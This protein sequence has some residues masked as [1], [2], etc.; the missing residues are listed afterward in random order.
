MILPPEIHRPEARGHAMA[1]G[2]HSSVQLLAMVEQGCEEVRCNFCPLKG[3][4]LSALGRRLADGVS[5]TASRTRCL[6]LC[7]CQLGALGLY[8][9]SSQ[10]GTDGVGLAHLSL[11]AN[12]LGSKGA[13]LAAELVLKMK[14]QRLDLES[15]ELQ[16]EGCRILSQKAL[17][18]SKCTLQHLDLRM[19][20]IQP[21]GA[22]ALAK[23]LMN[24][25]T[26]THLDLGYNRIGTAGA[27]ALC[28]V[29]KTSNVQVLRLEDNDVKDQGAKAL[30]ALQLQVLELGFNQVTA[31]GAVLLAAQLCRRG[32]RGPRRLGLGG[33]DLRDAGA[34]AFAAALQ[35]N[36]CLEELSLPNSCIGGAG[37]AA[38]ASALHS[39]W[40]LRELD[41]RDNEISLEA[42]RII[43]ETT[44]CARL[45]GDARPSSPER[46][47][48][49]LVDLSTGTRR[50][51]CSA[52][53]VRAYLSWLTK[54]LAQGDENR[55][56]L[57]AAALA[58]AIVD[59]DG[60]WYELPRLR[61]LSSLYGR[62]LRGG[63]RARAQGLYVLNL[64]PFHVTVTAAGS[65]HSA[66][67]LEENTGGALGDVATNVAFESLQFSQKTARGLQS[68]ESL[69]V[70]NCVGEVRHPLN[71]GELRV[72]N[73]RHTF[74]TDAPAHFMLLLW[75]WPLRLRAA[76]FHDLNFY[77][78]SAQAGYVGPGTADA[79]E[80]VIQPDTALPQTSLAELHMPGPAHTFVSHSWQLNVNDIFGSLQRSFAGAEMLRLWMA[81]FSLNHWTW[82][83]SQAE[84]PIEQ[85]C[86]AEVLRSRCQSFALVLG[87]ELESLKRLWCLYEVLLATECSNAQRP[88]SLKLCSP[89]GLL[90]VG[91]GGMPVSYILKVSGS[92]SNLDLRSARGENPWEQRKLLEE[93]GRRGEGCNTPLRNFLME[94]L[95]SIH[96]RGQEIFLQ[97][98]RVDAGKTSSK[99]D[100]FDSDRSATAYEDSDA[101]E[102]RPRSEKKAEQLPESEANGEGEE[103]QGEI[104]F[105]T[106]DLGTKPMVS[107]ASR[108]PREEAEEAQRQSEACEPPVAIKLESSVS[109]PSRLLV[110]APSAA[111]SAVEAAVSVMERKES[112]IERRESLLCEQV[113]KMDR[114]GTIESSRDSER[115][116]DPSAGVAA[117]VEDVSLTQAERQES[118][119]R[120]ES[121]TESET[122]QKMETMETV[123]QD[124]ER[125]GDPSAGVAAAVED[126]SLTQA[127]R[128]ESGG[129]TESLTESETSQ[130][131]ETMDRSGTIESSRDSERTGDPSASVAAAVEDVSLTQAE[132][133]RREMQRQESGGRT[134]S[135]TESETS[136]KIETMETVLQDS[137]RTGDP[138][139]GVAAAA[140]EDV[141]SLT[142]VERQES[143][144][145]TASLTESE[146]IQLMDR[147]STLESSRDG[148]RTGDPSA[149]V[150][151]ARVEDAISFTE[152]EREESCAA[153]SGSLPGSDQIQKMDPTSTVE[154]S[155]DGDKTG[156]RSVDVGAAAVK[157]VVPVAEVDR[158]GEKTGD[159]SMDV[160]AAVVVNVVFVTQVGRD[161]E[162]TVDPSVDVGAAL[163]K[164]VVPVAEV[165]RDGEKTVDPSVDVGAAAVKN[166]VPV[167][168]VDRDDDKTGDRSVDVGAAVVENVVCVTEV[169]DD[170]LVVEDSVSV[171]ECESPAGP[172]PELRRAHWWRD[173]TNGRSE[174]DSIE[175][176]IVPLSSV[177][178][179]PEIPPQTSWSQDSRFS[180]G[181]PAAPERVNSVTWGDAMN[182]ATE[183]MEF[184]DEEADILR[185]LRSRLRD[186]VVLANRLA[187]AIMS[188][189]SLELPELSRGVS[190]GGISRASSLQSRDFARLISV[191]SSGNP[192]ASCR[193]AS[194]ITFF[195]TRTHH[196]PELEGR[197]VGILRQA[198]GE[199]ADLCEQSGTFRPAAASGAAPAAPDPTKVPEAGEATGEAPKEDGGEAPREK[200][201]KKKDKSKKASKDSK[202]DQARRREAS[203]VE[204]TPGAKRGREEEAEKEDTVRLR[205]AKATPLEREPIGAR[206][207]AVIQEKVDE[208]VAKHPETFGLG[209][210]SIRGSA[211]KHFRESHGKGDERPSEPEGPPPE[212]GSGE[213]REQEG[214]RERRERSRAPLKKPAVEEEVATGQEAQQRW[215]KGFSVRL[216][217]LDP[218]ELEMCKGLVVLEGAYYHRSVTLAG[219][220]R[221]VTLTGG[222]ITLKMRL[223]GTGDEEL[224]KYHTAQA[225]P[226]VRAHVCGKECNQEEVADDLVHIVVG[227]KMREDG[228]D[229]PWVTNLEKAGPRD[230]EGD[231]LAAIRARAALEGREGALV[232]G[233]G[234]EEKPARERGASPGTQKKEKKEKKKEKKQKRAAKKRSQSGG[235]EKT[236]EA[237]KL[238]GSRAK[239]ACLKKPRTFFEGTGLDPRDRVRNRVAR[240]A[241]RHL[242]RKAEKSSSSSSQTGSG[243]SSSEALAGEEE[244]IFEQ[245]CKVRIIA[246]H[247]PGALS[248]QALRL[249]RTTLLQEI[250]SED[251][252]N[253]LQPVAMAYYRQ[254]LYSGGRVARR[255]GS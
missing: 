142:E 90:S 35:K 131:M 121:L 174:R 82:P 115:T 219:V 56:H 78:R 40:R 112:N 70:D 28:T 126:V 210:L 109:A 18:S 187:F 162:E 120:T 22:V 94:G 220:V 4:E 216:S 106:E 241:R 202:K 225:A 93:F 166:V 157:N 154:S 25:R 32:A 49:L 245:G 164:N 37:G 224:L 31:E 242:K 173:N 125:T 77:W 39:N 152:V 194:R 179:E 59:V 172:E 81:V 156:D 98:S 66:R 151:S 129:R 21:D 113:Q 17:Q 238:D 118:G 254:Q 67:G 176:N 201:E 14:L 16:D 133:L 168:E 75:S 158:D 9:F 169:E 58:S 130:K 212:R 19:N 23:A 24:N 204:E 218:R 45:A 74:G 192:C 89:Q 114:S 149:D 150:G 8:A 255:P 248:G 101:N 200:K 62:K 237:I 221:S 213:R 177:Q 205:E 137:E 3:S 29:L 7:Y 30:V 117:A 50:R 99:S 143:S 33:N 5:R 6:D 183:I 52:W 2:A 68:L 108:T 165:D 140:V 134:E 230:E 184:G 122:S 26:L 84:M 92:I 127:E 144:G 203:G 191:A 111:R 153:R 195:L 88:M 73:A 240:K 250:G 103:T 222:S 146:P 83:S 217:L 64:T 136:Q 119:G 44:S 10:L 226:E 252:P 102:E 34:A 190:E 53:S 231:E 163:V 104:G 61:E 55:R 167:A 198:A 244:T 42:A 228:A 47:D 76:R 175:L 193:T 211:A 178:Q 206:R 12:A 141:L 123:L 132:R 236:E 138:S 234:A 188:N 235:S 223:T 214:D 80:Q 197:V 48:E 135:L 71:N 65:K 229:E 54:D 72:L 199:L 20:G 208:Y 36:C 207:R 63:S 100:V 147:T 247:F 186:P 116:G 251:K 227:R 95:S 13:Q 170:D 46:I 171:T 182:S 110:G 181:S 145:R 124:S 139:A 87:P 185:D 96:R 161:G 128:Q 180:F 243:G 196:P 239:Q 41:L 43:D 148:Q 91:T 57:V 189:D 1:L 27:E 69:K 159:P 107:V 233:P 160:G 15:N 85:S 79:I 60:L 105:V 155:R 86:S 246:E 232:A 97:A 38:L 215:E 209:S 11:G 51:F 253:T 249:M